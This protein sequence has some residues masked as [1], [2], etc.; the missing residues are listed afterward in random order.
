MLAPGFP[1]AMPAA[2]TVSQDAKTKA[3][4]QFKGEPNEESIRLR[5][6]EIYLSRG[7]QPGRAAEDWE[8]ARREL[9]ARAR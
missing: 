6:Y 1:L 5:A 8:Q 4:I 3:Q 9:M 2:Q 7:G